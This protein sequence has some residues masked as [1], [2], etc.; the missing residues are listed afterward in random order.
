[1]GEFISFAAGREGRNPSRNKYFQKLPRGG[2]QNQFFSQILQHSHPS[3]SKY[4][5][6]RHFAKASRFSL[7]VNYQGRSLLLS[8]N[9]YYLPITFS[10]CVCCCSNW[11]LVSPVLIEN[12]IRFRNSRVSDAKSWREI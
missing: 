3:L 11:T 1:M 12:L 5:I 10:R 9:N 8:N 2:S 6:L 7:S 4:N